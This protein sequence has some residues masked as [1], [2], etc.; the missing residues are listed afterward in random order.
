MLT[1]TSLGWKNDPLGIID[2]FLSGPTLIFALPM[3][4]QELV[5]LLSSPLPLLRLQR[6]VP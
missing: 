4:T 5:T 3:K 2:T 1:M 6:V